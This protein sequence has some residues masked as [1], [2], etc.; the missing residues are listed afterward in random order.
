MGE[1]GRALIVDDDEVIRA[2]LSRDLGRLGFTC[3]TAGNGLDA[4]RKFR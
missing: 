3:A 2:T 4:A 1:Q